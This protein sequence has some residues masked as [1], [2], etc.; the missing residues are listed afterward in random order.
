MKE[1]FKNVKVYAESTVLTLRKNFNETV[2]AQV[3]RQTFKASIYSYGY[4]LH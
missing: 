3:N 4:S 2:K 1:T